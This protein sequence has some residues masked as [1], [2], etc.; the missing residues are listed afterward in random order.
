[1]SNQTT[2]AVV[3]E[4]LVQ[5]ATPAEKVQAPPAEKVILGKDGTPFDPERAMALI[6][7]LQAENKELKPKAKLADELTAAQQKKLDDEKTELEKER[8]AR[9]KAEADLKKVTLSEMR[10]NAAIKSKLPLEFADRLQGE[11]QEELEAD[12]MK[13]LTVMPKAPV[14]KTD[15]TNPG[16]STQVAKSRAERKAELTQTSVNFFN[17]TPSDGVV[18]PPGYG[19]A[20]G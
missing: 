11:T 5:N 6:E 9:L 17:G 13:L 3:T 1:M 7:K 15:T 20:E 14:L 19:G 16:A 12:A 4:T 2:Q 10:K 18:F 8:E